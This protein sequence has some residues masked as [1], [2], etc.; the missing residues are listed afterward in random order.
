MPRQRER[1]PFPSGGRLISNGTAVDRPARRERGSH[2]FSE[3]V[4]SGYV[5]VALQ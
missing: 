5:N 2:A 1:A 3:E 4:A